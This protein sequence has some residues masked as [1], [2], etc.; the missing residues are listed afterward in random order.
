MHGDIPDE[1]QRRKC[2]S[3]RAKAALA[4]QLLPLDQ[5]SRGHPLTDPPSGKRHIRGGRAQLRQTLYMPALVAT[6]FNPD[7]RAKYTA[8]V[9]AGK[10]PKVAITAVIRKLVILANAL[11]WTGRSWAPKPA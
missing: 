7:M 11:L 5:Q 3:P 10:P 6:R 8:L 9:A 1:P 4:V 2:W